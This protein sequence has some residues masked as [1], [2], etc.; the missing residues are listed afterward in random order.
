ML[1]REW[2][3]RNMVDK[4]ESH[5]KRILSGL[6]RDT[7]PK[8]ILD[9]K[10]V[11]LLTVLRKIEECAIETTHRMLWTCGAVFRYAIVTGRLKTDITQW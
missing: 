10:A 7:F 4:S 2:F 6:E 5:K 3:E 8:S 1:A 9:I 11:E